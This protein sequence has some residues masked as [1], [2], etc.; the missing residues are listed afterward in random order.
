M[1][2]EHKPTRFE[3][4]IE[5]GMPTGR[6]AQAKWPTVVGGVW[7]EESLA[8]Q[9]KGYQ[10]KSELPWHIWEYTDSC[11]IGKGWLAQ[12]LRWLERVRLF[13]EGGDLDIR[14]NG[15]KFLWRYVGES[16]YSPRDKKAQE[17]GYPGTD[18]SPIYRRERTALLWGT[19]KGKQEQWFD[20]RVSGAALTYFSDPPSLPEKVVERVQVKFR[21]YTQAGRT[22]AVW[23]MDLETV[24]AKEGK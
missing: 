24:R 1:A 22:V 15:N 5:K 13:G 4:M 2:T 8:D 7:T 6:L 20:D 21:E 11:T 17:L 19:R 9:L 3:T 18:V 12:E 10:G 16:E 14:R 23:L